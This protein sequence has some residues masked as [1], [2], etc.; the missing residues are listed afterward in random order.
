MVGPKTMLKFALTET[1]YLNVMFLVPIVD[2]STREPHYNGLGMVRM[3]QIQHV[4]HHPIVLQNIAYVVWNLE[5]SLH[6]AD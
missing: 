6:A 1:V 4:C 3:L 2:L 5:Y